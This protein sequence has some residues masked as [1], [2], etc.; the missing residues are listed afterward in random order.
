MCFKCRVSIGKVEEKG[1]CGWLR[2]EP[3]GGM[4]STKRSQKITVRGE[5]S[6]LTGRVS[7]IV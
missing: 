2:L 4:N 5:E 7:Y 1:G 6:E 3:G